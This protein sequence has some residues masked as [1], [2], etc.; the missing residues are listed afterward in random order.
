[1]APPVFFADLDK[2]VTDLFA[3]NFYGSLYKFA[4]KAKTEDN[5]RVEIKGDRNPAGAIKSEFLLGRIFRH[6]GV[7]YDLS[8]KVAL[9]GKLSTTSSVN[10]LVDGLK[11]ELTGT[12]NVSGT[13]VADQTGS[14]LFKFRNNNVAFVSKLDAERTGKV[15]VTSSATTGYENFTLGGEVA[16]ESVKVSSDSGSQSRTSFKYNAGAAYNGGDNLITFR[17]FENMNRCSIG[18][19]QRLNTSTT[20]GSTFTHKMTDDADANVMALV[21]HHKICNNSFWK[22]KVDSKGMLSLSYTN[23]VCARTK[24]SFSADVN[25]ADFSKGSNIGAQVSFE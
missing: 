3:D 7:E 22:G 23:Q 2:P 18:Y 8:S 20:I 25:T 15:T 24:L 4:F 5:A 16:A 14:L 6:E 12:T 9:D 21:A 11:I 1:M 13:K 19:W 17:T 10:N